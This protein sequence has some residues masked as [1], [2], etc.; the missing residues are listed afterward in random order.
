MISSPAIVAKDPACKLG[1]APMAT[2]TTV[3]ALASL[4]Q[5]P[6]AACGTIPISIDLVDYPSGETFDPPGEHYVLCFILRGS[7]EI[8]CK[9]E[10]GTPHQQLFRCGMF[11]P[12]TPPQTRAEFWMSAPMRHLMMMLPPRLFDDWHGDGGR[13][14]GGDLVQ[15][16]SCGFVD[17]LLA[18]IV[19]SVWDETKSGNPNGPMFADAL[20][21]AMTGAIIR[22]CN[23]IRGPGGPGRRL[24]KAQLATVKGYIADRLGDSLSLAEIAAVVAMPERTFSGAFVR[25]TGQSPYQYY[26]SVRIERAKAMLSETTMTISEI[27]AE[28]GFADQAHL[29]S[30]FCRHVG[31]PPA[32]YRRERKN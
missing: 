16:Q 18:S 29:T 10:S 26:L 28:L 19:R 24:S 11:L 3:K 30:V 2:G 27:A 31:A 22:A 4:P 20:R 8:R 12:L 21:V 25:S 1:F 14:F 6:R 7:G 5:L 32:R 23:D 9:L 13:P 15:L 17:P